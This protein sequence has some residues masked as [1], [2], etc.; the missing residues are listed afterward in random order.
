MV[1]M[2]MTIIKQVLYFLSQLSVNVHRFD[3][4]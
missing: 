4:K 2:A 3:A 1:N